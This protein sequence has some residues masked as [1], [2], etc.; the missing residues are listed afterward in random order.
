MPTAQVIW[1]SHAGVAQR[2]PPIARGRDRFD[3]AGHGW[4]DAV[5]CMRQLIRRTS[6]IRK[7][8]RAIRSPVWMQASY[9][10]TGLGY[11]ASGTSHQTKG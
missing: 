2:H 11:R 6:G 7:L 5:Q 1:P 10:L 8:R 9:V 4:V 3:I